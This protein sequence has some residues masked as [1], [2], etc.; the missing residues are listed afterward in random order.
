MLE[1]LLDKRRILEIYLNNVE[2]GEGVFGAQAAARHYFRVDAAQLGAVAGGAPGGDAA[3]AQALREAP[4][5][6]LRQRPRRHD[7]GAHGRRASC[8]DAP[9]PA[10]ATMLLD[11][12]RRTSLADEIAAAAAR[13]VVEEG[14]EY[15]AGQ[16]QGGARSSA[17][18]VRRAPSCRA[19]RRSRTRCASTSRCSAPT[20]S[21]AELHAL[22]RAGAATGWSGWPQF[23][24]HLAGAVWRGTATRLSALHIEL[25]CDD[26][27]AAEIA[28][29]QPA[30]AT[31]TPAGPTA[32]PS[33]S[34]C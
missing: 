9:R 26:P 3:G 28:L 10:R 34:T 15:G 7:R 11:L 29:H 17:R 30:R 19:T 1:A 20:P 32:R 14:M 21:P 27:K 25:Y 13:L 18:R 16:A 12:N 2:W 22:R 23:R 4:R 31:T 33:R 24:P 6:G 8:R 5:L